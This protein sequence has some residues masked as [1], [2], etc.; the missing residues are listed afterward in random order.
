MKSEAKTQQQRDIR[1]VR[2]ERLEAWIAQFH[3]SITEFCAHYHLDH[4]RRNYIQQ[5]VAHRRELGEKAARRLEREGMRPPGWLDGTQTAPT[6]AEAVFRF[7]VERAA[8]LPPELRQQVED[9]IAFTLS[10][11]E[12]RRLQ[13][14]RPRHTA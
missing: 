8:R 12:S 13:G 5:I 4:S 2:R 7:D 3:G 10:S 14:E 6:L 9:F 11:W 1:E